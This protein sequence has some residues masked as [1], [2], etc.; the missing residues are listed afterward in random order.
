M[1]MSNWS[2]LELM[3]NQELERIVRSASHCRIKFKSKA[4][5]MDIGIKGPEASRVY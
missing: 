1:K 3:G 4:Q 5:A 2:S